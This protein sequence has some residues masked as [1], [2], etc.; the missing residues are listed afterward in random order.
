MDRM[1]AS[2]ANL[3]TITGTLYGPMKLPE[4]IPE[5]SWCGPKVKAIHPKECSLPSPASTSSSALSVLP[6]SSVHMTFILLLAE[7]L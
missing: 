6:N 1:L 2:K 4:V 5:H 3:G 7:L